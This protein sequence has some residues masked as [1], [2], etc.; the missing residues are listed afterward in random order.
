LFG[1]SGPTVT[2]SIVQTIDYSKCTV[3]NFCIIRRQ[4]QGAQQ[5]VKR[6]NILLVLLIKQAEVV[7]GAHV[8][9][10]PFQSTLISEHGS[11]TVL[12]QLQTVPKHGPRLG[13]VGI[14]RE[15]VSVVKHSFALLDVVVIQARIDTVHH[16]SVERKRIGHVRFVG[17]R[18][19][20][21]VR[22]L[23]RH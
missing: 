15:G 21:L 5:I 8:K 3:G 12:H 22:L 1:Q 13:R 16:L 19:Q 10:I 18:C 2:S 17:N 20:R 7:Q 11:N 9:R 4:T 23:H 6:K 14:H